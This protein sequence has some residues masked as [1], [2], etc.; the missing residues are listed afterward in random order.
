MPEQSER[1]FSLKYKHQLIKQID[2]VLPQ[3]QCRQCG[4]SGCEPYASAIVEGRADINQ[5]PPGNSTVIEKIAALLGIQAKPLNTEHGYPKPRSVAVIDENLCIGCTFCIR[6]C[7][8]DAIVGAAKQMHTVISRECTGCELCLDPCPMD[9][10]QMVPDVSQLD[11]VK[12][13]QNEYDDKVDRA[14]RRYQ[15]RL[16]RLSQEKKQTP[17]I[18]D[19][20][21]AATSENRVE[22]VKIR[23]RIVVQAALERA[24]SIRAQSTEGNLK[25][26]ST[27][28]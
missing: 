13:Q 12:S 22:T 19:G 17:E 3:T 15:F 28:S 14:R 20:M 27:A 1:E 11:A 9:C 10:I 18:V 23:K 26:R 6:S 7:P 25:S 16:Q 4:F 24:A 5:C 8:V 2:A 21:K